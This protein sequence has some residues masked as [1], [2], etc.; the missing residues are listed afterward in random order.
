MVEPLALDDGVQDERR[1][2]GRAGDEPPADVREHALVAVAVDHRQLGGLE[3]VV[4][5]GRVEH[6]HAP[7]DAPVAASVPAPFRVAMT[8]LVTWFAS[9]SAPPTLAGPRSW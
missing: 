4:A 1:R 5:A 9:E 7:T 6:A 2:R 3:A 8:S